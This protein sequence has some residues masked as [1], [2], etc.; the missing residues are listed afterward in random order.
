MSLI[1]WIRCFFG[2]QDKIVV[3]FLGLFFFSGCAV[4][5]VYN[6]GVGAFKDYE[7]LKAYRSKKYTPNFTNQMFDSKN[8]SSM[9]AGMRDSEA[10]QRATMRPYQIGGRWYYPTR[11][12]V[13]EIF[14]GIASWYGPNF[15][16]KKTSNG[17]IYNMHAHTAASKVLPMNTIVRVYNKE[18]AKST[19]VRINDR[20]PFVEGRIIDLSNVAARE[21]DMLHK[22]TAN[23]RL[24][25]L[26]FGG[27]ISANYQKSVAKNVEESKSFQDE[28]KIGESQ[29]SIQGGNFSLQIGAF[30]RKEGA[31]ET[32]ERYQGLINTDYKVAIKE[33]NN[34]TEVVY[35]VFVTGFKSEDEA[36]YFMKN[37]NIAG[38]IIRE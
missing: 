38:I 29:N 15:H 27:V 24:E 33:H 26:G 7:G 9:I 22:G 11:V 5:S 2:T 3:S 20:G 8:N 19:I 35:R 12:D 34:D 30:K 36:S 1:K 16:A 32:K 21:I 10:I 23:I 6:G 31:M 13:G 17:E 4:D 37:K 25:V 28:F 18:N 14:D